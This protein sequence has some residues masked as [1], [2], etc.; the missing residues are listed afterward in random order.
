[1]AY[2]AA[3]RLLLAL[4]LVPPDRRC[5]PADR[6]Q[7][8]RRHERVSLH[9]RGNQYGHEAGRS[10]HSRH[11]GGHE[12]PGRLLPSPGHDSAPRRLSRRRDASPDDTLRRGASASIR[13]RTNR[14]SG[15]ASILP[16]PF[17]KGWGLRTS[18]NGRPTGIDRA[19]QSQEMWSC[20]GGRGEEGCT[21]VA[22]RWRR[23][24]GNDD[25]WMPPGTWRQ[26]DLRFDVVILRRAPGDERRL[27][28]PG[29]KGYSRVRWTEGRALRLA[30]RQASWRNREK[31]G[32]RQR[33]PKRAEKQPTI[34]AALVICSRHR[35]RVRFAVMHECNLSKYGSRVNDPI[36]ASG[37]PGCP[38]MAR[39]GSRGLNGKRIIGQFTGQAT[40]SREI[41]CSARPICLKLLMFFIVAEWDQT[42]AA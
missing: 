1:M 10:R 26:M 23:D 12:P 37:P 19:E 2:D 18:A 36:H 29:S 33:E 28:C 39:D 30:T 13:R 5:R 9:G 42:G 34:A 15:R 25:R 21:L 11:N 8:I 7:P 22:A 40:I 20:A 32:G 17:R 16:A 6:Q 4:L 27:C 38:N 24:G 41:Q 31:E 3:W 35:T 14:S